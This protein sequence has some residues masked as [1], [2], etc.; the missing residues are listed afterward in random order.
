MADGAGPRG[1]NWL[2]VWMGIAVLVGIALIIGVILVPGYHLTLSTE[3]S[4]V[5]GQ[6]LGLTA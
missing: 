3:S 6:A 2:L 5:V 4:A 1:V